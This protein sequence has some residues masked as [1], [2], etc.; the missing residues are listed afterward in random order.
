MGIFSAG[1][2]WFWFRAVLCKLTSMQ[3]DPTPQVKTAREKIG[4]KYMI[5]GFVIIVLAGLSYYFATRST[6][7]AL[8]GTVGNYLMAAGLIVYL[9]GRILRWRGR[10]SR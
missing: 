2:P 3:T 1:Y 9:V 7:P 6:H 5:A 4:W 10:R 8:H